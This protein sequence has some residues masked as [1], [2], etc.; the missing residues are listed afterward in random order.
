MWSS[1]R[2]TGPAH[3]R[4]LCGL[5]L[6]LEAIAPSLMRALCRE[7]H[8]DAGLVLWFDEG[9]EV[10]NLYA[11]NPPAP[12]A[13][14][15]WFPPLAEL[16]AGPH[17]P[18]RAGMPVHRLRVIETCADEDLAGRL[19]QPGATEPFCPHRHL[20][21][22]A[23]PS[24]APRQRICSAIL[25]H[26][27]PVASLTLFRPVTAA[28]FRSEERA[29]VKAAGRYLS[30]N[31]RARLADTSAAMYRAAGEQALLLC[32]PDGR[33]VKASANGYGLL[34]QASGCRIGRQTVPDALDRAGRDLIRR[35]LPDG[36]HSITLTNAWGLFRLSAF[37]EPHGQRG[38]LIERVEHLLVRLVNAIRQLDLS[39]QQG[40]VLLLLSQ[41]L[42]HEPIAE[43]L[44]VS[45]NTAD[46]HIRQLY[47]K[48]GAHTKNE[49]IALALETGELTREWH[50]GQGGQG[51]LLSRVDTRRSRPVLV[52]QHHQ[53]WPS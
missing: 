25:R 51:S 18:T 35:L 2:S 48:L 11:Q 50:S 36:A 1:K 38:V 10:A 45:H 43:R 29:A 4:R 20:C 17:G 42:S 49:A 44:G 33:V 32:E 47:S 52:E 37:F 24:G 5:G 28:A 12:A 26:G 21:G 46:Y 22:S 3:I 13:M 39:V 34:A 7:A 15:A 30:Q 19:A 31:G 9:G 14:A 40:E 8:C 27:T 41:G 16:N 23:V 53:R 6:P